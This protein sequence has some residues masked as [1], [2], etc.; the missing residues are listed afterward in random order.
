MG[1]ST[2]ASAVRSSPVCWGR[3]RA[4]SETRR[5]TRHARGIAVVVLV[6]ARHAAIE[7]VALYAAIEIVALYDAIEIVALYDAIEVYRFLAAVF[8]E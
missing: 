8:S 3:A 4:R 2:T 1:S 7:L 5:A 6:E